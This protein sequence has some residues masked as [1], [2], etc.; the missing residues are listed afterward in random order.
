MELIRFSKTDK[1]V[2]IDIQVEEAP[3]WSYIY[4]GDIT[5]KSKS[6][7]G[8]N[9]NHILG[10]PVNLD[11]DINSWDI[12]LG[13]IST[14]TLTATV[15]ITWTQDDKVLNI[16]TRQI[17]VPAEAAVKISDDALLEATN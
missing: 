9:S 6:S 10:L 15:T 3:V 16:W 14:S 7:A 17:D 4:V 2:S 12:R 1:P 11:D 13:N 8:G 5:F